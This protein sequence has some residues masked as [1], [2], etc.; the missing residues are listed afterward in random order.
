MNNIYRVVWNASH[1]AWVAV[2]ELAKGHGKS[3]SSVSQ[4][5]L[6]GARGI[7]ALLI[8]SS[9]GLTT[10]PAMAANINWNTAGTG[11]W[12]NTGNWTGG[13]LP[14]TGD[15]AF[16]GLGGG[17]EVTAG[18]TTGASGMTTFLGFFSGVGSQGFLTVTGTGSTLI[19]G[20]LTVGGAGIGTLSIQSAGVVNSDSASLG[21]NSSSSGSATVTGSGSQ[22][23]IT[24]GLNVGQDGIATLSISDGGAVSSAT[25]AI[26][27]Q[28][29]A[30]S[31]V[32]IGGTG[33][34]WTIGG[35]T[36]TLNLGGV[37]VGRLEI[38][39]A[40]GSTP[41]APGTLNAAEVS[42]GSNG[43]LSFKHNSDN[44][45]FAPN[46]TNSGIINL[47][48][49]VTRFTNNL[50]TAGNSFSTS[51]GSLQVHSGNTSSGTLELAAG[52]TLYAPSYIQH[53]T[54]G[55][56]VLPGTLQ[57]NVNNDTTYGKL[58]VT[59]QASLPSNAKIDVN[60]A[61]TNFAFTATSLADVISAGNLV[62]DGTFSVTDNSVLF[63]FTAVKDGNTVDLNLTAAGGGGGGGSSGLVEQIIVA[64]GNTP[65]I[66][67][68]RALDTI[69]ASD[70]TGPVSSLFVPLTTNE[71]VNA[72]V[73]QTLPLLTGGA[74]LAMGN[75]MHGLNRI[76]QA[77]QQGAHGRSSGDEFY[78]DSH[79]WLKPFGSWANQDDR[80][81]VSGFDA[82]TYGLVFGADAAVAEVNRLG[83]ALSYARSDVDSNSNI[84]PNS[85]DVDTYQAV[86]YGS[87]SLSGATEIN[88][89]SDVGYHKT[90]GKRS[91]NLLL[92]GQKA[93]G[94]YDSWSF[95]IGAG[96]A[97][98]LSLSDKTTITPSVRADYARIDS[99]SYTEKGAGALNLKVDDT[100][101]EEL[102]LSVDAKLAHKLTER[103]TL[104]ANMGVG[105]D[106]INESASITSAFA[107]APG[108]A[109]TTRGLNP[110]A[111]SY[112]GGLGVVGNVSETLE[113]TAR[114]D[115]ELKEDFDNQTASVKVR[116]AF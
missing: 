83:F 69:K 12:S 74:T 22:W 108:T 93:K 73:S 66:G 35:G 67:A 91:V 48:S 95:H 45:A 17:A 57:V 39:A 65:A 44:Y 77:R 15:V 11:E 109:F 114:Y 49:G 40:Q 62:S 2:S 34:T 1:Q 47:L 99:D 26:G 6:M 113:V 27:V 104:T 10:L 37:G 90:D 33:S 61:N 46:I 103:A 52:T 79:M 87:R 82:D 115:F 5:A 116:W 7:G 59:G 38:G 8:F 78:G 18:S 23:N 101:V 32:V 63:N 94:D 30:N 29:N 96:L 76:I 100:T 55:F 14:T 4:S 42:F 84:A 36:G 20:N 56:N 24:N 31:N 88:F 86:I 97:H 110:D 21:S 51:G 64:Q 106:A 68:A 107:G 16:I 105:Y 71:Q 13:V 9:L 102:I 80:K 112:R 3:K 58:A 60:V 85:A 98:T 19:T 25:G 92:P 43:S 89:Q 41:V 111:W 54:N 81:G 50:T 53:A 28:A 75:A 70:P 72:A